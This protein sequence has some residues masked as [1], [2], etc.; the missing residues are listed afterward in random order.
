MKTVK[1]DLGSDSYR[2]EIGRGLLSSVGEKLKQ[3]TKAEKIAVV[4]DDHVR[5]IYGERTIA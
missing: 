1:V 3:L 4:T 5:R 2:I